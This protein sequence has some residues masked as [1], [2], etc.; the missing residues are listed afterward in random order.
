M[1]RAG[2]YVF[3]L[4]DDDAR[5]RAE[6]DMMV[7]P[8]FL[9]CVARFARQ[10]RPGSPQAGSAPEAHWQDVA[11]RIADLPQMK[12]MK[13]AAPLPPAPDAALH[14][15]SP[16]QAAFFHEEAKGRNLPSAPG[17]RSMFAA[18]LL[19][20]LCIGFAGGLLAA[21]VAGACVT[22]VRIASLPAAW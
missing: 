7:D 17:R 11:Q 15:Q 16:P 10:V 19:G 22:A 6:H 18:G 5:E 9:A 20:A 14:P 3:G 12:G 2:A 1:A 21:P 4:M 13:D 8:E